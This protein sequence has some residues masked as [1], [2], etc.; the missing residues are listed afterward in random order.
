M[1]KIISS[2]RSDVIYM[3]AEVGAQ[4]RVLEFRLSFWL[5]TY[6]AYTDDFGG[7][8]K[9]LRGRGATPLEAVNDLI[10]AIGIRVGEW[11][12]EISEMTEEE[13]V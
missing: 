1:I 10:N 4:Q 6:S 8:F 2:I 11:Y 12:I 7:M 3:S 13:E 9:S 5:D